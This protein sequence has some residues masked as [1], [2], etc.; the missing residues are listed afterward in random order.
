MHLL[1]TTCARLIASRAEDDI[2]I[3]VYIYVYVYVY[4]YI[5]VYVYI[6]TYRCAPPIA[7]S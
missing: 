4:V 2:Y 1:S 6:C 5:H 3:Y 7:S